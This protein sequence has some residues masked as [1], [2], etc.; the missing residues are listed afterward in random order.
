MLTFPSTFYYVTIF[1]ALVISL[2]WYAHHILFTKFSYNLVI[3]RFGLIFIA[4]TF[5]ENRF[6]VMLYEGAYFG[7]IIVFELITVVF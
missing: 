6:N 7:F 1:Y 2:Y 5:S 4:A 3:I